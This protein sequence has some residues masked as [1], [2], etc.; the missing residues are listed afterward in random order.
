MVVVLL[1]LHAIAAAGE[2]LIA[3]LKNSFLKIMR[4]GGFSFAVGAFV[5]SLV[6]ILSIIMGVVLAMK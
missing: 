4:R 6:A 2:F 5:N 3:R 1:L